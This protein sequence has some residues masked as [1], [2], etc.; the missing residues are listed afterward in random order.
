ML[1][2]TPKRK[3][4]NPNPFFFHFDVVVLSSVEICL[5]GVNG[6]SLELIRGLFSVK[7]FTQ[8]QEEAIKKSKKQ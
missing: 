8:K 1:Q 6:R 2:L 3:N 7:T 4:N 5:A